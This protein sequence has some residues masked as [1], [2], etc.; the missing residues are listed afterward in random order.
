MT[1]QIC[2]FQPPP[3]NAI[4]Y[5]RLTVPI[6]TMVDLDYD[7]RYMIDDFHPRIK[8]E[9]REEMAAAADLIHSHLLSLMAVMSTPSRINKAT[10]MWY[11][12]TGDIKYPPAVIMD[13]DDAYDYVSVTNPAFAEWGVRGPDGNLLQRGA[14]IMATMEDGTME[15]MFADG[16]PY[17]VNEVPG[18]M[19]SIEQN[20]KNHARAK[21]VMIEANAVTVSTPYL[22][23]HYEE[24]NGLKNVYVFP[25]CIRFDHYDK[26][27]LAPHPKEIRIL[28]TGGASHFEDLKPIRFA[29]LNT[30]KRYPH[31]K[32]II[33]GQD[34]V[35]LRQMMPAEQFEFIEWVPFDRYRLK[36]G[37]LGH[38]IALCPLL[39]TVF[40]QSKSAI[41]WY[42][43][44]AIHHPAACIGANVGP[45]KEI[46]DGKTGLLYNTPEEFE[47]KLSTLIE[48]ATLRAELAGN[49]V[50]WLHE[51]RDAMKE[52]PKLYEFY[53]QVRKEHIE[54]YDLLPAGV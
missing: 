32:L 4:V 35:W 5:Y 45:Y 24:L 19:F 37:T 39:D 47:E 7:I 49:A 52:V 23:K 10:P 2:S 13:I 50:D 31:V 34:Y 6:E 33:F 54:S 14:Q 11:G 8:P 22:K 17:Y 53:Q 16:Q 25:N 51:N 18:G 36:L 38:D 29:L 12:D 48:N 28:W 42:E 15:T 30:L 21:I 20:Y 41:K 27:E 43:N 9:E 3:M 40:N 44:T 1:M 26:V 46:E